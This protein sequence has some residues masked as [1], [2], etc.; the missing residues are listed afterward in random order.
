MVNRE[1]SKLAPP[2]GDSFRPHDFKPEDD[3]AVETR[4][5]LASRRNG[6]REAECD[7]SLTSAV[8]SYTLDAPR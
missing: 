5:G 1:R 3:R 6:Q 8:D 4:R 7:H 2:C